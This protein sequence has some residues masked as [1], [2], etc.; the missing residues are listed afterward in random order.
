MQNAACFCHTARNEP[1][2]GSVSI[3][4]IISSINNICLSALACL[5]LCQMSK[6]LLAITYLYIHIY[7][8]Y[9]L[10]PTLMNHAVDVVWLYSG[11]TFPIKNSRLV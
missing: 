11:W 3:V 8:D 6:R 10:S 9:R 7:I 4:M 2:S 5:K 1:A